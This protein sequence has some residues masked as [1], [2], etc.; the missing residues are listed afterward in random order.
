M[1][2]LR[3][4]KRAGLLLPVLALT[5]SGL[6]ADPVTCRTGSGCLN[7]TDYFDW[8]AN[9]G[10]T[11]TTV[12]NGSTASSHSGSESAV[13]GFAQSVGQRRNE[14]NGWW[15]NFS[16]D[17]A[18]LWTEGDGPLTFLF[19]NP[20]SGLGASIQADYYGGFTALLQVYNSGGTLIDSISENGYSNGS[21]NGSAIFIGL[22][23]D[24][25]ITKAVFSLSSATYGTV[26]DFAI[27]QLDVVPASAPE[28]TSILLISS[29]LAGLAVFGRKRL[30][31]VV[32]C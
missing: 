19:N 14:S 13:V 23:N 21:N 30:L 25:G 9:F 7:G 20:L 24:S 12:P 29:A 26:G 27:D 1:I 2:T 3:V 32:R 28:P 16:P 17:E 11:F 5:S 8:A 15:G 10:P 18:L 31:K 22:N 6:L 4:L